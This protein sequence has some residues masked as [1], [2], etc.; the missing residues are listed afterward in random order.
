MT[1]KGDAIEVLL[2][3]VISAAGFAFTLGW[4]YSLIAT[5]IMLYMS[6]MAGLRSNKT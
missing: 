2:G 1:N 3:M 6:G 5:G 4:H